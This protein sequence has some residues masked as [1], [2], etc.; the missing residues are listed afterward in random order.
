MK[1]ILLSYYKLSR[2]SRICIQSF[3]TALVAYVTALLS[4]QIAILFSIGSILAVIFHGVVVIVIMAIFIF[5]AL[6][7]RGFAEALAAGDTRRERALA[8][9]HTLT[10]SWITQN[11]EHIGEIGKVVNENKQIYVPHDPLF[12]IRILVRSLY[13]TLEAHFSQAEHINERIEFE[14][15]FMTRSYID[16]KITIAAWANREGR[17]PTSLSIRQD[18]PNIY[19][20]T[21]PIPGIMNRGTRE[22]TEVK[23]IGTHGEET[24]AV[25]SGV[26]VKSRA[27]KP[28]T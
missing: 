27:G 19:D 9:A 10:D 17:M 18:H 28:A 6:S 13:E 8:Y 20:A 16:G 12:S 4:V 14:V 21:C 3:I 23:G 26:Q 22:G 15:T 5:I 1:K 25:H 2:T 7:F 24:Q 11:M